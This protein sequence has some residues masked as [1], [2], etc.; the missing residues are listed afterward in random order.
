MENQMRE[1]YLHSIEKALGNL[2]ESNDAAT[3]GHPIA[4]CERLVRKT[5]VQ[6][7]RVAG[8]MQFTSDL[9]CEAANALFKKIK[10]K[11]R[12]VD[13]LLVCTQTPDHLIPGVSARVHG[14]L[15]FPE[16]CFVLDINQ[17]CSGF[18]LATQTV[19]SL[20]QSFAERVI[21]INADTYSKLIR[22]DDL[23]TRIL[24]GDAATASFFS[25]EPG[26]L[27]VAYNRSFADGKGY[28]EFVAAG[29][30]LR[31]NES[32]ADGIHMDGP[33]I[34][35]FALR[36]VPNAVRH[37]LEDNNL[38]LDQIRMIAFHQAN[39]FVINQ[40]I[41]KMKLSDEQAPQNCARLGNT[42]SASIPLLLADYMDELSVG[43]YVLAVGFGVGLSWGVSLFQQTARID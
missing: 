34:L 20:M 42:V 24:F 5:G 32:N 23:T 10:I 36:V 22:P 40:L 37:A 4:E 2:V 27:R 6:S 35:N 31:R 19:T 17:G 30:A 41:R 33:A 11:A 15:D 29:S 12:D 7:R 16:Q 8:P 39:S 9:A 18:I 21:L 28:D 26:G 43:D 13:A 14:R 38:R 25:S 1:V 3:L